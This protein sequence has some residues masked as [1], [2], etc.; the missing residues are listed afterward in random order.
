M[1]FCASSNGLNNGQISKATKVV[2]INSALA[3]TISEILTSQNVDLQ[4]VGQGHGYNFRN[5]AIR[6]QISKSIK[7]AHCIL[8]C[9][10]SNPFRDTC[11][12]FSNV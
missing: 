9:A 4:K 3:Q 1:H 7:V 2:P 8:F 11:M 6:W 10:S 12:S 5:G